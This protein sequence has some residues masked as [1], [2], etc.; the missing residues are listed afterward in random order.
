MV[1]LLPHGTDPKERYA[2]AI[3]LIREHGH[4]VVRAAKRRWSQ[5]SQDHGVTGQRNSDSRPFKA[6]RDLPGFLAPKS[7]SMR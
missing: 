1:P 2:D 4:T 6:R 7:V 3:Q 5:G